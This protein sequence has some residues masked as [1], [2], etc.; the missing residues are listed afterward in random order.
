MD[1][2][3]VERSSSGGRQR[4]Y[5]QRTG[6]AWLGLNAA[7]APDAVGNGGEGVHG[8]C[9]GQGELGGPAGD[10]S[11]DWRFMAA[12]VTSDARSGLVSLVGCGHGS[13]PF[14][15]GIVCCV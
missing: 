3:S 15:V 7:A 4:H 5:G 11:N 13:A 6:P 12:S 2:L 14:E 9:R 10:E 8:R 1:Q